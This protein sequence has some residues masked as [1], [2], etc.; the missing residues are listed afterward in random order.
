MKPNEQD[1]FCLQQFSAADADKDDRIGW[2]DFCLYYQ[3]ISMSPA[4]QEIRAGL[5]EQAEREQK[6]HVLFLNFTFSSV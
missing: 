1:G 3:A 6:E 4:R 5:G 2:E